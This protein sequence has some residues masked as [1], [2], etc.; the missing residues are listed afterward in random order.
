[1][2]RRA[3]VRGPAV[4]RGRG[5][6][7]PGWPGR[8]GGGT[9]CA[10]AAPAASR[11]LGVP[12]VPPRPRPCHRR[13][14]GG[15]GRPRRRPPRLR[16]REGRTRQHLAGGRAPDGGL[17]PRLI[18]SAI[19]AGPPPA[20]P[21]PSTA[22][23]RPGLALAY[24]AEVAGDLKAR[25]AG[26]EPEWGLEPGVLDDVADEVAAGRGTEFLSSWPRRSSKNGE[27][28]GRH[29]PEDLEMVRQTFRRF[30]EEQV[31]PVAEEIHRHDQDIPESSSPGWRSS[32]ASPC[33]SPRSTGASR[34]AARTSC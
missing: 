22:R 14:H 19:A 16:V 15:L 18:T 23:R 2:T 25:V 28:G 9:L 21:G 11:R 32:A 24:A 31:M 3:V 30:A 1:V 8:A 7:R 29:L 13:R 20:V 6:R 5:R 26:R 4:P 17:R 12:R 34:P 33:P 10:P 27:A